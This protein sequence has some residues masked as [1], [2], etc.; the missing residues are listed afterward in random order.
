MMEDF[1]TGLAWG[2]CL[3]A[4]VLL[5]CDVQ[6]DVHPPL[7]E[8]VLASTVLI[9]WA[10]HLDARLRPT[11]DHDPVRAVSYMHDATVLTSG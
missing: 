7:H 11:L 10:L 9:T 6:R 2:N 1:W 8:L 5:P 3:D 4:V